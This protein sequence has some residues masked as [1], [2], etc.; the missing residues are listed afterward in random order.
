MKVELSAIEALAPD[1]SSLKAAAGL[2]KP[3]KWSNAGISADS[4]LI[5]AA[6]AGSGANPY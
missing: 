3:A 2:I 1:Q 4:R 6:C 5:W